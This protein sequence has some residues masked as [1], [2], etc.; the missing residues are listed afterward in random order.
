MSQSGHIVADSFIAN[1]LHILIAIF[2]EKIDRAVIAQCDKKC[3]TDPFNVRILFPECTV[4]A[5][6]DFTG[7]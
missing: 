2:R 3:Q 1:N 7:Q 6:C 4:T 5:L